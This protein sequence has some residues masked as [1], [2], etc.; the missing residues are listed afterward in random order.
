ML[1][2]DQSPPTGLPLSAPPVRLTYGDIDDIVAYALS[3]KS[4]P[5]RKSPVR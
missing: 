5:A 4:E 1:L 2:P 3:P